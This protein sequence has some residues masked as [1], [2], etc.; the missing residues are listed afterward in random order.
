MSFH[1]S[2]IYGSKINVIK[3]YSQDENGV[4]QNQKI[5]IKSWICLASFNVSDGKSYSCTKKDVIILKINKDF[6]THGNK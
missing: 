3:M 5:F 4:F 2:L 6:F 1:V